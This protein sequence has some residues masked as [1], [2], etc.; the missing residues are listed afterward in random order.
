MAY[1]AQAVISINQLGL[2]VWGWALMGLIIGYEFSTRPVTTNETR[3]IPKNKFKLR[4]AGN[5]EKR[6][7]P[8]VLGGIGLGAF[9]GLF[10]AIPIFQND[11]NFRK[12]VSGQD[13]N[14]AIKATL[15]SPEDLDRTTLIAA[16]LQESGL[17]KQADD[18]IAH[19]LESNPRSIAA[20]RVRLQIAEPGTERYNEAKEKINKLNP[21][22]PLE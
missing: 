17:I 22:L 10:I 13:A 9:I 1:E 12:A 4:R 20:W 8:K 21:R 19:V 14:V 7:L 6:N 18:L 5:R 3:E 16:R 15:A 2:G 11:A